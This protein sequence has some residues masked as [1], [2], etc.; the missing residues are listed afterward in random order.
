MLEIIRYV[1]KE[2][3]LK[4]VATAQINAYENYQSNYYNPMLT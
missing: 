1:Q 4:L 3:M 2:L